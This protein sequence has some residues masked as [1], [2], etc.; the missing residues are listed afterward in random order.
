MSIV[1][2]SAVVMM[3]GLLGAGPVLA[4]GMSN[5]RMQEPAFQNPGGVAGGFASSTSKNA[6]SKQS[7]DSATPAPTGNASQNGK[8][9]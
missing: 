6:A 4:Q 9:K 8:G 1:K 5:Q 2:L 7:A 3:V